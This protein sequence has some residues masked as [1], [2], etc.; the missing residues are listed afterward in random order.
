MEKNNFYE[1]AT[2]DEK[3]FNRIKT[4]LKNDSNLTPKAQCF[5]NIFIKYVIEAR[6]TIELRKVG[7]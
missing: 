4:I 3:E 5:M 2:C 7:K 1:I 6:K